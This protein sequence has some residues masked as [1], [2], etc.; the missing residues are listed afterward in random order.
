MWAIIKLNVN[1]VFNITVINFNSIFN[2][3][4][5]YATLAVF[6]CTSKYAMIFE[7]LFVFQQ[8]HFWSSFHSWLSCLAPPWLLG[9]IVCAKVKQKR[10][11]LLLPLLAIKI[12]ILCTIC[13]RCHL[14]RGALRHVQSVAPPTSRNP[15]Q[16]PGLERL[17]W[18][19][20]DDPIPT[21]ASST[22]AEPVAAAAY[23]QLPGQ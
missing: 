6:M 16:S 2:F 12:L 7:Q 22:W 17:C 4:P 19:W 1:V 3:L 23:L 11:L 14:E 20:C 18:C 13:H 8:Q 9:P 5:R 10:Q 21:Q 15:M